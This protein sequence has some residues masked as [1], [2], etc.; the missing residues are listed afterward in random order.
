ML[1]YISYNDSALSGIFCSCCYCTCHPVNSIIFHVGG[2]NIVL[3]TFLDLVQEFQPL[4]MRL[5]FY[6][7][8]YHSNDMPC[9][10]QEIYVGLYTFVEFCF[11]NVYMYDF[12]RRGKTLNLSGDPVAEPHAYSDQKVA[13]LDST[14]CCD[15]SVHSCKSAI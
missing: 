3:L 7:S 12:C 13:L 15:S 9:I 6:L 11:I 10:T 1:T 8:H 5:V 2:V 4:I 14:V